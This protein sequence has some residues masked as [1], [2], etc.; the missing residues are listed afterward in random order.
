MQRR[1]IIKAAGATL[2][3]AGLPMSVGYAQNNRYAKFRGTKLVMSVPLHPHYD[4]MVKILNDFEIETGIHVEL[5]RLPVPKMKEKQLIELAKPI[6]DYDLVSYVVMWK[7]EYVKKNL[8]HPLDIFLNNKSL[9]SPSYDI[10]DIIP[11]YLEN[12][13]LVGGPKGYLPGEG[14]RLYGLPYGAETS[15]LAYRRDLFNKH[16]LVPPGNYDDFEKLLP[17]VRQRTGLPALATRAQSGHHCVHAW[18]LHL[19]PLG[20]RVFDDAWNPIFNNEAGVKAL[21]FLKKITDDGPPGILK[22]GQN[23]MVN[24][25]LQGQSAMY[26]D[27]SLIFSQVNNPAV[28]KIGG[29]VEYVY[30]PKGVRYSSQSGGLGLAIPKNSKNPEAAFLLLQ[31]LTSKEQD[32]KVCRVGGTPMRRSTLVDPDM[33]AQYPEFVTMRIQLQ[34]TDPDWRPIIPEWDD[35]NIQALGLYI[36]DALAGNTTPKKALDDAALRVRDI[37]IRGGYIK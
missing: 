3:G 13:G 6:G 37:M 28:S 22:F 7:G 29:L 35:I 26:L 33:M 20:G 30:H 12:I 27:S 24:S 31:W 32:K 17:V 2:F 18:L 34:H 36:A 10:K 25:F 23:E 14:A 5:D 19:N 15:V 1:Q 21:T 9:L 4:A 8:I 16:L 11:K